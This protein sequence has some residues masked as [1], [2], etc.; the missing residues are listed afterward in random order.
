MAAANDVLGHFADRDGKGWGIDAENLRKFFCEY[1]ATIGFRSTFSAMLAA[2]AG[3]QL[4]AGSQ[5]GWDPYAEIIDRI[6]AGSRV[7]RRL[8]LMAM[9]VEDH[10]LGQV[11]HVVVL[12]RLYGPRNGR[13]ER[14][15]FGSGAPGVWASLLA[16]MSETAE[17]A[18]AD[19]VLRESTIRSESVGSQVGR[20]RKQFLR[21][22]EEL[23]WQE[24]STVTRLEA[25]VADA[26]DADTREAR[27]VRADAAIASL[28]ERAEAATESTRTKLALQLDGA[29]QRRA[30]L[31]EV[32]WVDRLQAKERR[33]EAG[34]K[35]MGQ[36]VDAVMYDGTLRARLGAIESADR[37]ITIDDAI[38]D[39]MDTPRKS[40]GK[41]AHQAWKETREAF[42]TAV[43]IEANRM[44]REAHEAYRAARQ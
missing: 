22:F 35:V 43:R 7:Y 37:E 12:W 19:L 3:V 29:I 38:R 31:A 34:W 20:N 24:A 41:A 15:D 13:T 30:S 16:S 39:R 17:D 8:R 5:A 44:R 36:I 28:R 1:D 10:G 2:H 23:F 14:T 9:P 4:G 33:I 42:V 25:Q 18:R 26:V 6:T 32:E 27:R 40:Q 21:D 11:E